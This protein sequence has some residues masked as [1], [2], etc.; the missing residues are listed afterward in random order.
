[1]R[2]NYQSFTMVK[3]GR[4]IAEKDQNIF[5]TEDTEVTEVFKDE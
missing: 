5:T 3:K 2:R 4:N 1:M